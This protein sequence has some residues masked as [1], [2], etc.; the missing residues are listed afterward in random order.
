MA[1]NLN[2]ALLGGACIG[3]TL[4]KLLGYIWMCICIGKIA[5]NHFPF[6]MDKCIQ[7]CN[8]SGNITGKV[9]CFPL[10]FFLNFIIWHI[11]L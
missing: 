5:S 8:V 7:A 4:D 9:F 2:F 11:A 6:L 10:G 1:L 3:D